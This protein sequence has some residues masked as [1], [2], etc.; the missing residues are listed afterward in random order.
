[1]EL[2]FTKEAL[3]GFLSP[4]TIDYHY[5]KHHQTYVTKLNELLP[6]SGFENSSLEDIVMKSAGPL[7]NNAA[8]VW[9]HDFYWKGLS[10]ESQ[11]PGPKTLSLIEQ[12]WGSFEAFKKEFDTK[13]TTLFGSGWAWLVYDP[14]TQKLAIV[15]TSNAENPMRNGLAPI[16]TCDVWEHAYYIDYRNSRPNYLA[17]WWDHINWNFVESRLTGVG[18]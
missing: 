5:G 7:F 3:K 1:M 2:P 10:P 9:N 12:T 18:R 13:A 15:Q 6:G 16:L 4:E 14:N 11:K 8:Q 17:K